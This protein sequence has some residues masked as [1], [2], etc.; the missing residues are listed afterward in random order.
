PA[1]TTAQTPTQPPAGLAASSAESPE[2]GPKTVT[3]AR[4]PAPRWLVILAW[5][6]GLAALYTL[7]SLAQAALVERILSGDVGFGRSL[8][9]WVGTI[10]LALMGW[11]FQPARPAGWYA[12]R[13]LVL[14]M[15]AIGLVGIIICGAFTGLW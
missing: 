9:L 7:L 15:L 12:R 10:Y 13:P 11:G 8:A 3:S 2:D 6:T 14:G 5:S 4:P 1:T